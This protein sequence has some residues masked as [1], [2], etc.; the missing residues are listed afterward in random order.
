MAKKTNYVNNKTLYGVIIH[1]KNDL[2]QSK[3]EDKP[4]PIVQKYVGEAIILIC[5][6]I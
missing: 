3:K 1:Y 5:N 2:T 6:I 4:K